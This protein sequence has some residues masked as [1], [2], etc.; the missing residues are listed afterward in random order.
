MKSPEDF[1]EYLQKLIDRHRKDL[2]ILLKDYGVDADPTPGLLIGMMRLYPDFIGH[3][4]N[5]P[6]ERADGAFLDTLSKGYNLISRGKEAVKVLT[7]EEN[8]SAA[9]KEDPK[10]EPKKWSTKRIVLTGIGVVVVLIII[11][12]IVKRFKN[13]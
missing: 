12:A 8:A 7:G 13:K 11:A 4:A 2:S 3:L 1:G 6:E 10:P 9:I 5:L